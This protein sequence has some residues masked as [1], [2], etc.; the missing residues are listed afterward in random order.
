MNSVKT[1]VD[2]EYKFQSSFKMLGFIL[3]VFV[4]KVVVKI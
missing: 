2:D 4:V 1:K 3:M